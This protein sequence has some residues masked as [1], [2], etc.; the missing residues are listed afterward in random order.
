MVLNGH[1]WQ[2]VLQTQD[3]VFSYAHDELMLFAGHEYMKVASVS[4]KVDP[5]KVA[6]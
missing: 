6:S 4:M 2:S 1:G 5:L 3:D